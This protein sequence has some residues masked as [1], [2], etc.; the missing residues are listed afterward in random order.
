[1]LNRQLLPIR[2]KF[3]TEQLK[4]NCVKK[5]G[6]FKISGY[7]IFS[8]TIK[9]NNLQAQI[10]DNTIFN[11]VVQYGNSYKFADKVFLNI[12]F[13]EH[14]NFPKKYK[15]ETKKI[16]GFTVTDLMKRTAFI[17]EASFSTNWNLRQITANNVIFQSTN[18]GDIDTITQ[19]VVTLFAS[20]FLK[21][22][23]IDNITLD[24]VYNTVQCNDINIAEYFSN[25]AW[26]ND[27]IYG[28]I[29]FHDISLLD[30]AELVSLNNININNVVVDHGVQTITGLK[31][32]TS[33]PDILSNMKVSFFNG[34]NI[35][36]EYENSLLLQNDAKLKNTVTFKNS[37]NIIRKNCQVIKNF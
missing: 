17:N 14:I 12:I 8:N 20:E 28:T 22:M 21:S 4:E 32:F 36:Q 34:Y 15:L 2:C 7:K 31:H 16:N 37:P 18:K 26:T 27:Y 24:K 19:N 33:S 6:S 30:T 13:E 35:T 9:I 10:L 23:F 25:I 5:S 11:Q 3:F 29:Y 1:M